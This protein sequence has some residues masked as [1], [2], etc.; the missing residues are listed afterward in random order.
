MFTILS[1][2][3]TR[4]NVDGIGFA[5]CLIMASSF[6]MVRFFSRVDGMV[7]VCLYSPA[8]L[9]S[10]RATCNLPCIRQEATSFSLWSL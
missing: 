7:W 3:Y 1:S 6:S 8:G 4:Y 2:R 5:L 10:G 9:P